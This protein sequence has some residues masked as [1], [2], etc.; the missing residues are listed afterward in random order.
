MHD[1]ERRFVIGLSSILFAGVYLITFQPG[2]FT[3]CGSEGV[4]HVAVVVAN[5]GQNYRPLSWQRD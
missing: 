4:N 3:G 1:I 5:D 2:N